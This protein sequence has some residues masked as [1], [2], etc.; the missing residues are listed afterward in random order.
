VLSSVLVYIGYLGYVYVESKLFEF[1]LDVRGGVQLEERSKG[2]SRSVIMAWPTIL[3]LLIAWD[4]LTL[5]EKA[6]K[7]FRFGSKVYVLLRRNNRF[8]NFLELSEYGE[9][10]RRSFIII[11]EG[12]D[13]K[14]WTDC[15]EQ[16]SKLKFYH[17]KQKLGR[18]S[19][20]KH[21]G[22]PAAGPR[23]R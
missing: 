12:E 16:L 19:P 21:P 22:K 5:V 14:A 10:G 20:E 18:T 23:G 6:R 11:P 3:W 1:R 8:R 13:G 17:E 9:K 2:L 4:S 7:S 15:R